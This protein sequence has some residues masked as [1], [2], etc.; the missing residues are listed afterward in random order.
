LALE[1]S[2]ILGLTVFLQP[3]TLLE[4]VKVGEVAFYTQRTHDLFARAHFATQE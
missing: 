2:L 4:K 1:K 3:P